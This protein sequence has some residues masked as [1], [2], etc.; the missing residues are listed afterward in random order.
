MLSTS[1]HMHWYH[2]WSQVCRASGP[3]PIPA[4][5][6]RTP[7]LIHLFEH[8]ASPSMESSVS[9]NIPSVIVKRVRWV[10][11]R[12]PRQLQKRSSPTDLTRKKTRC[13]IHVLI[14]EATLRE[15]FFASKGK[16]CDSMKGL[17]GDNGTMF[18]SGVSMIALGFASVVGFKACQTQERNRM[19]ESAQGG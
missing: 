12:V 1:L 15:L 10:F 11:Q 6:H 18:S 17:V 5:A 16:K 19:R 3:H 2:H 4:L 8:G 13:P 9:G 14:L 7:L